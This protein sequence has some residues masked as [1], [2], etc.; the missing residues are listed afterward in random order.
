M[1]AWSVFVC[2]GVLCVGPA[3]TVC[4]CELTAW[5]PGPVHGDFDG[6]V[7]SGH[8][9][10]ARENGYGQGETLSC[11]KR[12]TKERFRRTDMV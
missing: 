9:G 1:C 3:C 4:E 5:F 10:W 7:V 11:I 8:L 12:K 6:A 2:P